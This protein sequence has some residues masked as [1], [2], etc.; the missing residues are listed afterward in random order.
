MTPII[1]PTKEQA[2]KESRK[3]FDYFNVKLGMMPNLYAIMAYFEPGL[4]S[5][6][7][8][9]RRERVL[10]RQEY[11]IVSLVV[12]AMHKAEYCL[13]TH[14]MIARLNGLDDDQIREIR[15]GTAGF[16]PKLNVLAKLAHSIVLNK[17]RGDE[18]ILEEFFAAGYTLPHLFD[19]VMAIADNVISNIISNMMHVPADNPLSSVRDGEL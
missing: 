11:E 19:V 2:P 6:L 5:Y 16:D 1:I 7:Q 14:A 3:Y 9:Q 18:K 10:S 15:S 13:E 17:T 12:S 4:S 8:L